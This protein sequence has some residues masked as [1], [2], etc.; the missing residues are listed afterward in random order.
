MSYKLNPF[1]QEMD[2][3]Y[4]LPYV[5]VVDAGDDKGLIVTE[6]FSVGKPS[7][8]KESV[9]GGGDSYGVGLED[10][11]PEG[12]PKAGSAWHCDEA[13]TT[14]LT[15]INATDVTTELSS[16]T[17][18]TTPLF[19]GTT[20]GKYI[21]VGSDY[22]FAGVKVKYDSLAT[23]ESDNVEGAFLQ[24]SSGWTNS[25]FMASDADY[26]YTQLGHH[27]ATSPSKKE[28]WRLGFNP[29]DLPITWD[30]V[31]L[32]I[33]G[34]DYTKYWGRFK[35]ISGITGD[36]VLEQVKLHTDRMEINA[37]GTSEYFG[38]GRYP[39]DLLGGI[40]NTIPNSDKTPLD[41][42][43]DIASGITM[44]LSK[45]EFSHTAEDGFIIPINIV[46]GI[47]TSIP[48]QLIITGY[49]K[50]TDAGTIKL[51]VDYVPIEDGFVFDGNAT[52]THIEATDTFPSSNLTRRQ[53]RFLIPINTLLPGNQMMISLY[54]M[55]ND[56]QD[57]LTANI[58]IEDVRVI[59]YHWRP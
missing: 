25:L 57:T 9:F 55:G 48:L 20:T 32:N 31:T 38:R 49:P 40:V 46:E 16:D 45:N 53:A 30:K 33:N 6:Q 19:N 24:T 51:G 21:L 50:S 42:N 56:I 3:T 15:I 7:A 22:K 11:T 54:R 58:V 1:T 41:E 2:K 4:K 28:Q 37:D 39:K 35:I 34:T 27:V 43:I 8:S 59:G 23:V 47:D 18:S 44:T 17:G 29:E 14:G 5:E 10:T 36:P 26:P 13:D 12:I 52:F